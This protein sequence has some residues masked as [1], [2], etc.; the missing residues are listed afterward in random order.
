MIRHYRLLSFVAV[1]AIVIS[2]FGVLLTAPVTAADN[3]NAAVLERVGGDIQYLASDELQGRA[4][5][6][7]G[8]VKAGEYMRDAF[9]EAGLISGVKDGSYYQPFDM[10]LETKLIKEK[11]V[12]VLHGPDGKTLKLALGKDY[13]ALAIGGSGKVKAE[14]VFAGYEIGRASCRERV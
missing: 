14:I 11:A 8:L 3:N 13:Q 9:K 4:P 6:T 10:S 7:E 2:G 5:G 1:S 12:L